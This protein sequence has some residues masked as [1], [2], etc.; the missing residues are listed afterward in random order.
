MA[1]AQETLKL[2]DA[3]QIKAELN[4][5]DAGQV[6]A[7]PGD[8]PALDAKAEQ[9]TQSLLSFGDADSKKKTDIKAAVETMGYE[10]QREAAAQSEMLKQPMRA[11]MKRSED[12][13]EVAKTLIDLKL[14]VETL[15]PARYDFD[16]GWFS[17]MMGKLPGVGTPLKRY[18]SRFE[19]SQTIVDA[20]IKSLENG[21]ESLK[22][23][24]ITLQG[25]QERM[26]ELT[27]KLEKAVKLGQLLDEKITDKLETEIPADDPR[28]AFVKEEIL[29]ALRQ[30]IMDL[31]QQLAVNQQGVLATEIIIRNNKELMRGVNRALNV[32]VSALQVAVTVALALENQ[33]IV[34]DKVN[35]VSATTNSLIANTDARLKTQGVEIH[36]QAASAQLNIETLKQAFADINEAMRDVAEFR[37]RALPQMAQS[38]LEMD[39]LANEAEKSI[40]KMENAKRAEPEIRIDIEG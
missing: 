17:R 29:F 11:M 13:G 19:T 12:G 32:T 1:T 36:K 14:H 9:L 3:K 21:R 10:M 27:C 23:D 37:T 5:E 28:A 4:L 24:N 6:H 18:F 2:E 33:K 30:R 34:L 40:K 22:R 8:D 20:I 38:I 15:D 16:A 25:D 26:R 39:S 31:Q 7:K 35:A